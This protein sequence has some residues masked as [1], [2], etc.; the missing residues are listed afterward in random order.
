MTSSHWASYF[1]QHE[2]TFLEINK[3][4]LK[5]TFLSFSEPINKL[6][7]NGILGIFPP[8]KVDEVSQVGVPLFF[9]MLYAPSYCKTI[10]LF[11]YPLQAI[12]SQESSN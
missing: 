1:Q 9:R 2:S 8:L 3:Q 12:S 11:P 6:M 4:N 10:S 5:T 7:L